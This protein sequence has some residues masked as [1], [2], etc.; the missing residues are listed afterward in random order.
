MASIFV[1]LPGTANTDRRAP[2]A[3]CVCMGIDLSRATS[4]RTMTTL[5]AMAA[6]S[7]VFVARLA[8]LAVLGPD[9]ESIGRVRDLVL[10][11]RYDTAQPRAL[12]LAVE[13]ST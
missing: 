1:E 7:K 10:A 3:D 9:G 8:G 13:L 2:D 4:Q 12:G 6:V 5:T 11:L